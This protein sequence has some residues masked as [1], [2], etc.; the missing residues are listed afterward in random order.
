MEGF[1]DEDKTPKGKETGKSDKHGDKNAL[2]KAQRD[3]EKFEENLKKATT[4]T[5]RF[6]TN[7]KIRNTS[8]TAEKN[9][10]GETH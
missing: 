1:D 3:I 6:Q 4:R 8:K 2:G 10:K 9:E 7:R 5:E